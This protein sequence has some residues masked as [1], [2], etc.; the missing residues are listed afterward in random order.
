MHMVHVVHVLGTCG[1]ADALSQPAS[2]LRCSKRGS[3]VQDLNL[4][5]GLAYESG[6]SHHHGVRSSLHFGHTILLTLSPLALCF[7]CRY[8]FR[9][10]YCFFV[11]TTPL[12]LLMPLFLPAPLSP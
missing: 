8:R 2:G 7:H 6:W 9:C 5:W 10:H 12:L 1:L 4:S 3:V 11:T